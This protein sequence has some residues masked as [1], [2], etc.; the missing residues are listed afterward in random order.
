MKFYLLLGSFFITQTL[1]AQLFTEVSTPEL[2]AAVG[3]IAVSDVNG[4]NH[5]DVLITG[6]NISGGKIAKL[7]MNDGMGNFTEIIGTTFDGVEQ[8]SIAFSDVND[9][10]NEDI[11]ITGQDNTFFGSAKLYINDGLGNFTEM[12]GTTF[13]GV[14][15]SSIAFSDVNG[16]NHED[17]LIT[18]LNNSNEV[19]TK[20]YINDGTG[21]FT[22]MIGTP[23]EA[24]SRGSIAFADINGNGNN[25]VLITGRNNSNQEITKLYTNDGL[26]NFTEM[27][28]TPFE[29]VAVS[30]IAFSDINGDSNEDVLITGQVSSNEGIAKIYTNDGM[31]NFSEMIGTP[32]DGVAASSIAFSDVNGDGNED[33]FISGV[34][35][36]SEQ[37]AKLYINDGVGNFAEILGTSFEGIQ[38]GSIAF[39][40]FNGNGNNDVLIIGRNSSTQ[41]ST[42]LYINEGISSTNDLNNRFNLSFTTFPNPL[43]SNNLNLSFNSLSNDF[44]TVTIF[45]DNGTLLSQYKKFTGIGQQTISVP[46]A[47]LIP[48]N[49]LIQLD[50][51]K[52]KGVAKFIVQ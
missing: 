4:D 37:I 28:G 46:T 39:S 25:D 33:V 48:G 30:S 21:I 49:Y 19:S 51:G 15:R 5:N 8:S 3:S 12:V 1:F 40:D 6:Q 44:I 41:P 14:I 47:S 23:F 20:L 43:K 18:G 27:T 31:G 35:N 9:D 17:V 11:L 24:I 26:G 16:D 29:G 2:E 7:Y 22:E 38:N 32:F 36:T 45:G 50:N 34:N 13:A 42:K 52:D 10:G